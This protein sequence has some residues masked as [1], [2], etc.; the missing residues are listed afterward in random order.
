M[1]KMRILVV[2]DEPSIIKFLRANLEAKGYIARFVTSLNRSPFCH[3]RIT[4]EP[5][6]KL[7]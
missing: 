7:P 2:D 3:L 4:L 1:V 6:E 5:V